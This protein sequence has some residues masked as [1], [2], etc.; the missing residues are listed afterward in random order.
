[1][2]VQKGPDCVGDEMRRFHKGEMHSG[3]S[4]KTVTSPQQAKAIAMSVC[5][6]S[7]YAEKLTSLGYSDEAASEVVAIFAE[8]DWQKQFETGKGP[9]PQ[10]RGNYHSPSWFNR[11][12]GG[13]ASWDIESQNGKQSGNEGKQKVNSDSEMLSGA[14]Y[15]KGPGNPQGGSSKDVQGLR[16][17]G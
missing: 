1:M 9:G 7:K 16:M 17:L 15:P 11:N 3:K 13:I 6:E 12:S 2:P 4:K 14:S 8:L 10:Q 5:G